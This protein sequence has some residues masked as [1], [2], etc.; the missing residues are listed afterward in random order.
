MTE[1]SRALNSERFTLPSQHRLFTRLSI[2]TV[3][4]NGICIGGDIAHE[5]RKKSPFRRDVAQKHRALAY[6]DFFC[7]GLDVC[8]WHSG[9]PGDG[10]D[11]F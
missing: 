2:L 1:N 6:S 9:R 11:T 7:V 8:A 10:A 3:L 5:K 4:L